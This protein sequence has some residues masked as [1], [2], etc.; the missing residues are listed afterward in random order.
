MWSKQQMDENKK[1]VGK[2]TACREHL[3][4]NSIHSYTWVSSFCCYHLGLFGTGTIISGQESL[5]GKWLDKIKILSVTSN[6]IYLFI[7]N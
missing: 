3:L 1:D 2:I 5:S 7:L 4:Y 6:L